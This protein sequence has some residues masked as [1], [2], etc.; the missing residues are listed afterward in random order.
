MEVFE[1]LLATYSGDSQFHKSSD[2]NGVEHTVEA[3]AATAAR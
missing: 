3:A 1:E 2:D